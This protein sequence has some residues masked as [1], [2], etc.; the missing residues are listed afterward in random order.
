MIR[1]PPRS[2]LFPYTTLFRSRRLDARLPE[3]VRPLRALH[4]LVL[5][6]LLRRGLPEPVALHLLPRL[7]VHLPDARH[8]PNRRPG[9]GD[10]GD[11]KATRRPPAGR[12][13]APEQPGGRAPARG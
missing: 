11:P 5:Q 3:G 10:G 9:A 2:T 6:A 4:R 1:R 12:G 7:P 13:G 8:W